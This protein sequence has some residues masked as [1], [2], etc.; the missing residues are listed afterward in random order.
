MRSH[1]DP[2]VRLLVQI[3]VWPVSFLACTVL[4]GLIYRFGPDRKH[5]RW[6]WITW[7]SATASCLWLVGTMAFTWY[8]EHYG[9]YNRVHG[10]LG[11]VVGFLTW[12]WL[13]IVV[14]LLGAEVD[15]EL[16]RQAP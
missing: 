4:L 2:W 15:C 1:A 16:E 3:L 14:L 8:A 5:P 6:R 9:S 7:G 10:D 13:S 11:A 12:V